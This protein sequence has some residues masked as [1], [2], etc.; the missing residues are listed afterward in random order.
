MTLFYGFDPESDWDFDEARESD[1]FLSQTTVNNA[2]LCGGR[3]LYANEAG[4]LT[5]PSEAMAWGTLVHTLAEHELLAV[6]NGEEPPLWTFNAVLSVWTQA[7]EDE[8]S[9]PV[10]LHALAPKHVIEKGVFDAQLAIKLW[11][12]QVL[13]TLGEP[14]STWQVE[15]RI[16][17]PIGNLD[18]TIVWLGGTADLVVDG[19]IYDWKTA[20]RSWDA[21]KANS[22]LQASIYSYLYGISDHTYW[23]Y[24]RRGA[25]WE[26]HDTRRTQAHVDAALKQAW[27]VAKGIDS[28]ALAFE[29]WQS[30]FGKMKRAW[31]CSAKFCPAWN[32]CEIKYI[33][34]NVWEEQVADP[35]EGWIS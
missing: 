4:F 33:N 34:D 29:P 32:V 24:G 21:S 28:G 14:D 5:E 30:T 10:D 7:M 12:E 20:G 6:L 31:Y 22:L 23:V 3:V 15:E 27:M 35:K 1:I 19:H 13:P 9:G 2:S 17:K 11:R 26:R 25:S 18:N 16:T 8:R